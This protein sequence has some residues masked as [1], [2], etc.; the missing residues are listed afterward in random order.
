MNLFH[1]VLEHGRQT[2]LA[3]KAR[4]LP[5]LAGNYSLLRWIRLRAVA[6]HLT[7][8]QRG[9]LTA[10]N[11][12]AKLIKCDLLRRR[13][14]SEQ[15]AKRFPLDTTHAV[16]EDYRSCAVSLQILPLPAAQRQRITSGSCAC[17]ADNS[18]CICLNILIIFSIST[19]MFFRLVKRQ[20]PFTKPLHHRIQ[21]FR[22]HNSSAK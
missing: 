2:D 4:S 22:I 3:Y 17:W 20:V 12:S 19:Q 11:G 1:A 9:R 7:T 15:N 14:G 8:G 10:G 18:M 21:N 6:C 5:D 13:V 16:P